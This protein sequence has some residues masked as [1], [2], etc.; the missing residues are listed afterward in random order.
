MIARYEGGGGDDHSV[1]NVE[2]L[3]AGD[4]EGSAYAVLVRE[5]DGWPRCHDC[6]RCLSTSCLFPQRWANQ[7]QQRAKEE[8]GMAVL[9]AGRSR[10]AT[11]VLG[12]YAKPRCWDWKLESEN[13][14]VRKFWLAAA[15]AHLPGPRAAAR[16]QGSEEQQH[17]IGLLYSTPAGLLYS[18]P[19]ACFRP[20]QA[21]GGSGIGF[22]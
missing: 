22:A 13:D 19:I 18:T 21:G 10:S 2:L 8:L 15:A 16:G 14:Q 17:G 4:D 9:S 5:V 12:L 6:W 3:A 20:S 7:Q 1:D 11:V